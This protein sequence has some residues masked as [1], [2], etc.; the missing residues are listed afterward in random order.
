MIRPQILAHVS[1]PMVR[2]LQ[3][4]GTSCVSALSLS[5]HRMRRKLRKT[6]YNVQVAQRILETIYDRWWKDIPWL[7]IFNG[8]FRVSAYSSMK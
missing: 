1:S 5:H 4:L 6:I 8:V 2:Y 7:D 3:G